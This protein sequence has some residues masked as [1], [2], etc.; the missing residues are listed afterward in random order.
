MLDRPT[1]LSK[2]KAARDVFW[3]SLGAYAL[4]TEEPS[5]SELPNFRICVTERNRISVSREL[6]PAISETSYTIG[7]NAGLDRVS[8]LTVVDFSFRQMLIESFQVSSEYAKS[9]SLGIKHQPWYEF[10]RHYRNAVAHNGKWHFDGRRGLPTTWRN[11]TVEVSM[12]GQ[13]ISGF[14]SWFEG[15]QLGAQMNLFVSGVTP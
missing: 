7:F 4:L 2:L 13:S 14:L 8:A 15:L 10:A 6:D 5:R 11:R 12:Q 3:F 9:N 1:A